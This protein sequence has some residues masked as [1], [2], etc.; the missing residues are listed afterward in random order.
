[1]EGIFSFMTIVSERTEV[2]GECIWR[3]TK[4]KVLPKVFCFWVYNEIEMA[5]F[6]NYLPA[7]IMFRNRHLLLVIGIPKL[8]M[9]TECPVRGF[10]QRGIPKCVY[11]KYNS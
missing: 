9:L 1:M 10:C 5:F 2:K 3:R 11:V 7:H 4:S 6:V 8:Q